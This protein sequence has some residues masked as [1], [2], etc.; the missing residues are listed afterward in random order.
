MLSS[1]SWPLRKMTSRVS[2]QD[3]SP[4]KRG[5]KYYRSSSEAKYP[6]IRFHGCVETVASVKAR[7]ATL[8]ETDL[9]VL[10][11]HTCHHEV[12]ISYRSESGVDVDACRQAIPVSRRRQVTP[13]VRDQSRPH[14]ARA[15]AS[16]PV[17]MAQGYAIS[18]SDRLLGVLLPH[19][20]ATLT[21]QQPGSQLSTVSQNGAAI[22][23][24]TSAQ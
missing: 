4:I 1:V 8:L 10:P 17:Y 15:W 6:A 2:T 3:E 23:A 16:I 18:S 14:A 13:S 21:S 11:D 19:V 9:L 5:I 12:H 7:F 20:G 22:L 24:H